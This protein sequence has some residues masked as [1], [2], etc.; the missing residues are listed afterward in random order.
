MGGDYEFQY[1]VYPKLSVLCNYPSIFFGV[2][3]YIWQMRDR[4]ADENFGAM[5][6][7]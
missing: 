6:A 4:D 2:L 7:T 5:N 3:Q 1:V